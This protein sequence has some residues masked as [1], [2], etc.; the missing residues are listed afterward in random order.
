MYTRKK[1]LLT[2]VPLTYTPLWVYKV[3]NG[4]FVIFN[5]NNWIT[6]FHSNTEEQ[7]FFRIRPSHFSLWDRFQSERYPDTPGIWVTVVK[8]VR[9]L[10]V[11][12][13]YMNRL[14]LRL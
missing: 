6:T 5:C 11:N 1:N 3:P 9:G 7:S 10:Y 2:Y 4:L 14:L 13:N 12:P 8:G